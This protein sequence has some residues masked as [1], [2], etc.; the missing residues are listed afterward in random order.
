[1]KAK[2]GAIR[3]QTNWTWENAA[4]KILKRIDYLYGL[5]LARP[6]QDKLA[7]RK[8]R[9]FA[10][11]SNLLTDY[12]A[13]IDNT[14]LPDS[15]PMQYQ[16]FALNL[17]AQQ[18]LLKGDKIMAETLTDKAN[19]LL[20]NLDTDII[21]YQLKNWDDPIDCINYLSGLLETAQSG[22]KAELTLGFGKADIINAGA[23]MMIQSEDIEG[24]LQML[25]VSVKSDPTNA[26]TYSIFANCYKLLG[27]NEKATTMEE[28]ANDNHLTA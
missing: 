10:V 3:A 27:D 16:S 21:K 7:F 8:N 23:E 25:A 24:A 17:M 26:N 11:L 6:Y 19:S 1:M 13:D 12:T 4:I 28:L 22:T 5:D 9:D 20:P 2:L 14:G 15:L 18:C